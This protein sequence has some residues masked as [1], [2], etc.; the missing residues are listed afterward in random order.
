MIYL[1]EI[2]CFYLIDN[3]FIKQKFKIKGKTN[4]RNSEIYKAS[5]SL[6]NN[7]LT[8]MIWLKLHSY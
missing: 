3:N 5:D 6:L 2:N 1:A 4:S 8:V 7:M